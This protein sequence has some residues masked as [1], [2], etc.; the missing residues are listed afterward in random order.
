MTQDLPPDMQDLPPDM[1]DR[2]RVLFGDLIE[3]RWEKARREFDVSLRGQADVNR[4]ADGWTRMADSAGS[5]ERMGASSVRQ[6]GDYTLVDVPLTFAAGK[7][8]GQ[9]VFARDG[10]VSGMALEYPRR[11]RLD[12]RRVR[13]FVLRNP[14][15]A[16]LLP[17]R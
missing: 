2:A 4:L 9:V 10:K 11:R 8:I 3:G 1:K 6:S 16:G 14:E 17:A 7:A 12:P 15:I 13:V 5:F